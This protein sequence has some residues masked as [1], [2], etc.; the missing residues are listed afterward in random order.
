MTGRIKDM[1]VRA[2]R[3]VHPAEIEEVIG[4]LAGVRKGRVAVFAARDRATGT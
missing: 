4:D 3:N 2:G 1:I